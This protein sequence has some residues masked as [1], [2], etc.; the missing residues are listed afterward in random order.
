VLTIHLAT[1]T[2]QG[3][4]LAL[5]RID[6]IER[7]NGLALGVFGV[8]AA[9]QYWSRSTVAINS[10]DSVTD[11]GLEEALEHTTGLLVDHG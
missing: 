6:D 9:C 7:G 1:E 10:R 8:A 4:A 11:D 2:V 3:T 5:Q